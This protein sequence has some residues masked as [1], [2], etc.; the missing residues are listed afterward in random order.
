MIGKDRQ[1]LGPCR[2]AKITVEYESDDDNNYSL[3]TWNCPKSLEKTG[4]IGNQ[5]KKGDH[6]D[7]S[8]GLDPEKGQG[9]L[10]KLAVTQS[11]VKDPQLKIGAKIIQRVK[12][13][14]RKANKY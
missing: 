13:I 3:C 5:K 8:I 14:H 9:N 6:P 11:L 10:N 12:I 4:G 7:H 1:I 2:R